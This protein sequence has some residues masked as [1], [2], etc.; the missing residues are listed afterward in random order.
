MEVPMS[1]VH[2]L[3]L[4]VEC[5]NKVPDP[6]SKQGVS[7]QF[8]TI[9]AL[10]F[11][12]LVAGVPDLA[13]IQR[14]SE[15]HEK[16][17]KKFLPFNSTKRKTKKIKGK[18]EKKPRAV[19]HAITFARVLRQLSLEHLQKAFAEF[20]NA[21]LQD[22]SIVAAVDGKAAKQM[23]DANGDPILM[24]NVF[25]QTL[26]LHLASWN[27]HGDQTNEPTC[28]KKHLGDLFTMFPCLKL[29]T[30]DAIFAQRPLLEAIQEYHRDYL[31]QVKANQPKVHAKMKQIF[32]D[33]EQQEPSH[34]VYSKKRELRHAV[35][36]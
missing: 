25:A 29:L 27:V 14:W 17:L 32:K 30:G 5:L 16:Q 33:A 3:E 20:I 28:L 9:L 11:L 12:G 2:S 23:K 24:L 36:G 10:V 21:I 18:N 13:K 35:C 15:N 31:F 8:R 1:A 7:H 26:K 6:R 4:F 22:T 19:P 34:V